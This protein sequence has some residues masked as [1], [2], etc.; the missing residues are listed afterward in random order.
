[1]KTWMKYEIKTDSGPLKKKKD[2]IKTKE[3]LALNIFE[4]NK[5]TKFQEHHSLHTQRNIVYWVKNPEFMFTSTAS[6]VQI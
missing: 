1:M 4:N 3:P 2:L 5:Y 6:L